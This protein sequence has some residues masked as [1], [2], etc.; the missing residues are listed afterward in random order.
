MY[1][2]NSEVVKPQSD[3]RYILD[4]SAVPTNLV[5]YGLWKAREEFV[6]I[7]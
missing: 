5:V 3:N 6:G 4:R 7:P 2:I 1:A